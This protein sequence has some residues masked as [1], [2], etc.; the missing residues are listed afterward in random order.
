MRLVTSLLCVLLA[1]CAASSDGEATV[2]PDDPLPADLR[3]RKTGSDWPRFLGPLGT[4]VSTEKGILAPW[5]AG[6]P[7]LVWEKAIGEGYSAPVISRGRLYLFERVRNFARLHCWNAETAEPLWT[8]EY[9][10]NYK[11]MYNYSGGPRCC[12]VVDGNRVYIFGPEGMLHCVRATDGKL[13]WKIDTAFEFGVLQ[14]FFGVGSTPVVEDNLLL[15][16]I[17]G[18]PAGNKDV[19][20]MDRKGNGTGL[21]AFDKFTGKIKYKVSDELASYSSPV[22]T[23]IGKRRWCLL[24]AR[25]GLM[26][27]DPA[28]GKIDFH[29]PWRANMLESV[30]ASNPVVVDNRVLISECYELG[31]ALLEIRPGGYRELWTDRAKGRR[32]SL[33]CH[34]MTPIH[35]DG[36]VYGSSGRHTAEAELQCVELTTGKVM[37]KEPALTRSSLLLVHGHFVCLGEDGT[38]R[39]LRVNPR[40]YDL[41]ASMELRPAGKDGKPDPALKNPYWA[42]PVLANGLLYVRGNNRLVCLE[43]IP[44]KKE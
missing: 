11:D 23:T 7:K 41:V 31:S 26:G 42:A 33:I 2:S 27:L 14:N 10:T 19:D 20:F 12:P 36:Y 13:V 9:A 16:Q 44:Q 3:T 25:G 38:L 21:V 18:S 39:L 5:P 40:K 28:T 32:K 43:L 30:N 4:S 22:V 34:W 8:F 37:W 29:Y 24:F 17:G 6:G 35:V 1:G 15:V